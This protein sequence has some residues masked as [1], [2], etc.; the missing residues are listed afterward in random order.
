MVPDGRSEA[1]AGAAI[2]EPVPR[3]ALAARRA[4]KLRNKMVCH[5]VGSLAQAEPAI[6]VLPL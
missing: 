6:C 1:A 4:G 3:R 2:S 5:D